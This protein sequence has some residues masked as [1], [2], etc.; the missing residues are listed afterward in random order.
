MLP[1]VNRPLIDYVVD[2]LIK[3]GV[4][5]I[6]FVISEH[7]MQLIH[8]YRENLRLYQY[9]EKMNKLSLYGQ[10]EHLHTKA[11][12]SFIKQ[13]DAG[14]YGTGVPVKLA[15]N[16]LK[17][18]PAFFVFMGDDFLFSP[19]GESESARMAKLFDDSGAT[20]LATC[21]QKPQAELHRYGV[22]VPKLN[23]KFQMLDHIVE[24]PA[25]GQSPSDLVNISKYIFTPTVFEVLRQQKPDQQSG[26]LYITDTVTHLAKNQPVVIYQ[27]T[28]EYL[29]GG[30]PWGWLKANLVVANQNP[31]L[32]TE[33]QAFLKNQL[34][35]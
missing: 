18:E 22:F 11:V 2:D 25:P 3:S 14:E 1:I 10:I 6:I 30:H 35:K 17:D 19:G 12:F 23:G 20:A 24:K 28:G 27:P 34:G 4:E 26:E 21:I 15:E 8:Y 9:L 33:L 32:K 5:E 29:D 13:S 31:E 7:N 16:H